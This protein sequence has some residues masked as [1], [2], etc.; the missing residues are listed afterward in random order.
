M[1]YIFRVNKPYLPIPAGDISLKEAWFLMIFDVVVGL[2]I[3]RWMN[4]DLITTSLY[5]LGL[6]LATF[7]STP[8][9]RFKASSLA[10]IIVIPLVFFQSSVFFYSTDKI[11][12]PHKMM[13]HIK[14][15]RLT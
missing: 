10:T 3:L 12:L 6:V 5:C 13:S 8:P 15:V 1:C 14:L 4:A 11:S 7:Y 2:L 9:F